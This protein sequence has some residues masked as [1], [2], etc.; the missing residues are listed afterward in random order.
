MMEDG[1]SRVNFPMAEAL[2]FGTLALHRGVQLPGCGPDI[3]KASEKKAAAGLNRGAYGVSTQPW[4]CDFHQQRRQ[5]SV[6][7]F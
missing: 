2:A 3:N 6:T 7:S 4:S 1:D 5:G